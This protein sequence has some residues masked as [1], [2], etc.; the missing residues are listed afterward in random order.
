VLRRIREVREVVP[1][2][3][4]GQPDGE[5]R[6]GEDFGVEMVSARAGSDRDD[7]LAQGQDDDQ[8]VA[9]AEVDGGR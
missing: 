7:G 4:H 1:P 5:H 9:L 6:G 8:L 3:S 2:Q